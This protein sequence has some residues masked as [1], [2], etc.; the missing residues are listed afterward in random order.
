MK[1]HS[2]LLFVFLFFCT[3]F[4]YT[5]N[6]VAREWNEELLEAIRNDFARPTVHARNL[7]HSSL[8]MYDTWAIFNDSAETVFLGK[9]F[10][11]YECTFNGIS[12]PSEIDSAVHEVMSYAM[13]R[14]L[15][16]RFT[17]SPNANNTL[18][19]FTDLFSSY[20]YDENITTVDY[21]NNSFA[22]LGNYMAQ[23]II[24]F[25]LQDGSNEQDDYGNQYY[26]PQNEP[27]VLDLYEDNS[28]INPDKWQPLAFDVF[29]DQSGNIYPL[30]TPSFLTPEWGQVT[31]FSLKSEDLEILNNGFDSYIYNDPGFP[32]LI[33]NSS[34]NGI[35][36]PYKWNFALVISWSAHLDPNDD[37]IIDISPATLGNVDISNY[38][39][40]FEEYVNFYN[41]NEGGATNIGHVTNPTTGNPYTPQ[42]VKRGDY[43]RVL[44]EFWA[45]GPDSETPP[46]H[47][48]TILNYVSDHPQT[49]KKF[50]GQGSVISDLE[51]DVKSYLVL[52]GAMHDSAINIWGIKGYYDYT[53]PIS[54]IRYMAS[55][56][57]STDNSLSN[58]DP[59][60]LPLIP[61]LIEVIETGDPLAFEDDSVL[62]LIKVKSWKGPEYISDPETD[63]AGVDWILGTHW[64]PYQRPTFVTPPFAGYLSGHS[65]FSRAAAVAL[66]KITGSKFFP[67]GLGS[68]DVSENEFLV[69]EEG[70]S[71][72]FTLE[73]ATYQDASDQ[74]SLS[75]IWGGIHPP[76][77]DIKG[78][79]IGDKIGEESFDLAQQ[80]FTSSLSNASISINKIH[81][82]V[83]PIPVQNTL[84]IKT[85]FLEEI[86]LEMYS[87]SGKLI[88]SSKKTNHN[89][90]LD[91]NVEHLAQG[92]YIIK[93]ISNGN[94]LIF[95]RKIIK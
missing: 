50:G 69:F 76:I 89:G 67:G 26:V 72:S 31:P 85:Q 37:S 81:T 7:F 47:W 29:I 30:E 74:T 8:I 83:Y 70:P 42:L 35:D 25:G 90:V 53:R 51:W 80:Y 27:L 43:A 16:H 88:F 92:V 41:F 23:E 11:G 3:Q 82:E 75:R 13:Y 9:S 56:G 20:G 38:P 15:T 65:T 78:R 2:L 84:H 66:T 34:S 12:T 68:F 17:N 61:G 6:S 87:L 58:F 1:L 4:S 52:G 33:Q 62:G 18:E 22:A 55:K 48:F 79:I 19:S 21:S 45:D 49:I 14:L 5:Q 32:E 46:G 54:A 91:L 39:T 24:S 77:D 63:T 86:K 57:Q 95:Q 36:D 94:S 10:G 44:A 93:G 60:G 28:N 71:E 73:W 59:H 40:T 64:W